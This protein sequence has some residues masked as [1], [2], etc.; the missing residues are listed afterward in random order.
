VISGK[1]MCR[2]SYL[3]ATRLLA[4]VKSYQYFPNTLNSI[5]RAISIFQILSVSIYS[6]SIPRDKRK[7]D[8]VAGKL[9]PNSSSAHLWQWWGYTL[10]DAHLVLGVHHL[11][12]WE[13]GKPRVNYLVW[14]TLYFVHIS[15]FDWVRGLPKVSPRPERNTYANED[16][17]SNNES[18]FTA[19]PIHKL[20]NSW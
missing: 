13:S 6:M 3:P 10:G 8:H 9:V 11:V 4:Y 18:Y 20:L 1:W 7:R 17:L 15:S 2:D 12:R 19:Y 14:P 5:Y 16:S